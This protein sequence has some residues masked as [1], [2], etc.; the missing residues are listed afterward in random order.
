M[1]HDGHISFLA[2]CKY[3]HYQFTYIVQLETFFLIQKQTPP[4]SSTNMQIPY[5]NLPAQGVGLFAGAC[6]S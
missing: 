1:G 2:P 6:F 3:L 5:V 4:V